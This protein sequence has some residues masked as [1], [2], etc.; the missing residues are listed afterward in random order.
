LLEEAGV[1]RVFLPGAPLRDI[2]EW[3]RRNVAAAV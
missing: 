1:S 2:V 3:V